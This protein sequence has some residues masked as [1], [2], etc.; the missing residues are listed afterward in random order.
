[1]RP[2]TWQ[3]RVR[4]VDSDASGRIHYT[5]MLRY[6]EAAEA[7][8]FRFLGLSY[9]HEHKDGFGFPRVHVECDY[10]GALKYEDL[11]DMTVRVA[12]V[13]KASFTLAFQATVE[14]RPA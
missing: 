9:T 3:L 2:F 11:L 7:E 10:T 4:F 13:G 12:R 5:A 8:F 6:F 14:G 1:M